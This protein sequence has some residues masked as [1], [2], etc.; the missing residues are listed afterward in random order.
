MCFSFFFIL[1]IGILSFV[2][3][4]IISTDLSEKLTNDI[5]KT[6]LILNHSVSI[7]F[8]ALNLYDSRYDYEMDIALQNL[9]LEYTRAG[10][11]ITL[12]NL[13]AYKEKYQ[14]LFPQDVDFY[15]IN[16]ENVIAA[17]TFS[18]D[19]GLNFSEYKKFSHTLDSIR[20]GDRFVADQ[21]VDS[22]NQP[23]MYR[24]YAY[25][26]TPDHQYIL[27]IGISSEEFWNIRRTTFSFDRLGKKIQQNNPDLLAIT[28]FNTQHEAIDS[29]PGRIR[30]NSSVSSYI[31]SSD[32]SIG[33]VEIFQKKESFIIENG[34][35]IIQYQFFSTREEM[36]PSS[37]EMSMAAVLVYSREN[38][39]DSLND[40]LIIHLFITGF[41]FFIAI[42]FAVYISR[43]IT[44]PLE[45][46]I[47]DTEKIA[48][49]N[50]LH[51]VTRAGGSDIIRLA[52]SIDSMVKEII[53][54]VH[55]IKKSHKE[56]SIELNK[57]ITAEKN[58]KQVNQKLNYLSSITR[59]DILNQVTCIRG[60]A[61]LSENSDNS[62][63]IKEYLSEIQ[64]Q[65][66]NIEDMISFSRDYHLM[67]VAA[68]TWQD[69]STVSQNA[70]D[71]RFERKISLTLPKPGFFILADSLLQKVFYNLID[72][73]LKHGG[74][75]GEQIQIGF[76]PGNPGTIIYTDNGLGVP[77][78]NKKK[79]FERGYGTGTGLGLFLIKEILEITGM[80]IIETGNYGSGVRFEITVPI[81]RFKT[82]SD[83]SEGNNS[84]EQF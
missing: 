13:S 22:F 5:E 12:L 34:T 80:S 23:G 61:F 70:A 78:A 66:K 73:S 44:R 58:L 6:N 4:G 50:Y 62:T 32:L 76:I 10:G 43:N 63:E 51:P 28:F 69:I 81:D 71:S 3:F 19:L 1:V 54:D 49:G 26:P 29:T 27:E 25:L 35:Q 52:T 33:L 15:L 2:Q 56:T 31:S 53:K 16:S 84:E 55:E 75:G 79:I 83:N 45:Q 77:D 20:N 48:G 18:P 57:R 46:I 60:Y 40:Y 38:L 9:L 36:T 59:H 24:K 17:T 74:E 65:A 11:D 8:E 68:T 7:L 37:S 47:E 21:W 72:N 39:Q 82:D 30:A 67:G 42:L 14:N 64:K 41:A